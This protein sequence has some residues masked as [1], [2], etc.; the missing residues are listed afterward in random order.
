MGEVYEAEDLALKETL[1]IKTIRHEVLRQNN[2][3]ARFKRE[4]HLARK[5]THPNICRVFDIFWH[6]TT[7]AEGE[8]AIVFVSME[9]LQG[10]TLSE[11]IRQAGRF[12]AEEALPLINQIA[13]GLEAAH[14]AGVA[15]RD[16]KLG[17][18]ILVND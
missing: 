17:N 4:V 8:S 15:H 11:R 7:Q 9:L 12:T 3:L 10:E 6:K 13:A 18:V 16:L 1:A 14:R 5:V 2:A